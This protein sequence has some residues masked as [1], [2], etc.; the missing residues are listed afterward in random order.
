MNIKFK[1]CVLAMAA[2][3]AFDAAAQQRAQPELPSVQVVQQKALDKRCD[4]HGGRYLEAVEVA[5]AFGR[6][7][8]DETERL[9]SLANK[10][11]GRLCRR[12]Y[13]DVRFAF[14][15][16]ADERMTILAEGPVPAH[17]N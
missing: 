6:E 8:S 4:I 15:R 16:A 9:R 2:C 12:G 17:G 5:R 11:A 14:V 1:R 3:I 10:E 13:T 7:P